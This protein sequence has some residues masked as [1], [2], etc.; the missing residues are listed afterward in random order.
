M[1]STELQ[2]LQTRETPNPDEAPLTVFSISRMLGWPLPFSHHSSAPFPYLDSYFRPPPAGYR[3]NPYSDKK[4]SSPLHILHTDSLSN[5]SQ[6]PVVKVAPVIQ[7]PLLP[8]PYHIHRTASLQLPI[9]HLAKRGGN[10]HQ[11]RI[12]KI[13]GNLMEL[14]KDLTEALGV[15]A[16]HIAVNQLTKH[17]IIKVCYGLREL[18]PKEAIVDCGLH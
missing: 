4:V 2:D 8:L 6:A 3:P 5:V 17:I 18:G 7:N 1:F 12:R 10:L 9:Y 15:K 16:E 11:T 14:K 13:D